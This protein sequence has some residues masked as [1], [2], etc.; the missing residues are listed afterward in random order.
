MVATATCVCVCD[1]W[2][3]GGVCVVV[4]VVGVCA[5]TT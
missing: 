5:C 4:V 3:V 1:W 2:L